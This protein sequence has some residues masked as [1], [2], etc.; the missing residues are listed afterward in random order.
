[1]RLDQIGFAAL[2]HLQTSVCYETEGIKSSD[3]TLLSSICCTDTSE[4]TVPVWTCSAWTMFTF[5]L[6]AAGPLYLKRQW[7]RAEGFGETQDTVQEKMCSSLN[8]IGQ[9]IHTESHMLGGFNQY[10]YWLLVDRQGFFRKMKPSSG[11]H[12]IVSNESNQFMKNSLNSLMLNH[13]FHYSLIK[14]LCWQCQ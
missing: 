8:L 10:I 6:N 9:G 2:R 7:F 3:K 12:F 5:R 14:A 11:L 4:C 13:I 1:M